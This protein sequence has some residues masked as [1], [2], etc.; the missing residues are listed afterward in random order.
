MSRPDWIGQTLGDRYQIQEIVGQGGMSAVYK[1]MDPNLQRVVAVKL[2]HSHLADDPKFVERFEEEARAVAQLRHPNIVQVYDFAEDKGVYYMVQEFVP[3]ET[4]QARM[5]R[6]DKS[7][8]NLSLDSVTKFT[9]DILSAMGYAHQR[10][11]IHRDIKPANIMLDVQGRAI[12]MDFGI[13]KIVGGQRHTATGAVVGTALY[14][15]P[16]LIR[17]EQPDERSDIYSLGVT[18]FEMVSGHPPFEAESAMTL[19]MMHLN[20]PLPNLK[21]LRPDIP[22]D[23]EAV[24]EKALAKDRNDRYKS[25]AEMAAALKKVRDRLMGNVPYDATMP[26]DSQNM[27]GPAAAALSAAALSADE[28][29][30]TIIEP[31]VK[32]SAAATGGAALD[33]SANIEMPAAE[34]PVAPPATPPPGSGTASTGG[35]SGSVPPSFPTTAPAAGGGQKLPPAVLYGG[36]GLI[37]LLAVLA[38]GW[39]I[40]SR[41]GGNE[42]PTNPAA[43]GA[44]TQ[45]TATAAATEVPATN[46]PEPTPTDTLEPS[47]TPTITLTPTL[48]ALPVRTPPGG[49]EFVRINGITIN[50]QGSYSVDYE[51]FEYTEQLPGEH[52][53]FFFNTVPEEQAGVPGNGPWILYGGPRPFTEYAPSQRPANAA[54]MCSL[55]ANPDHSIHPGSGTCWPLPDV[56][57]LTALEDTTCLS[58]PGNTYTV[59]A[60]VPKWS[61]LLLKGRLEQ[62]NWWYVQNPDNLNE[63]CW[64][65]EGGTF[66]SGPTA[67]VPV[68]VPVTPTLTLTPT[69]Y[70]N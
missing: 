29:L 40:G 2:V 10:G 69:P 57:V 19:M 26:G 24:I 51:T 61:M 38:I 27:A 35:G 41:G 4:L 33:A 59:D 28:P 12:L 30:K 3:G 65:T 34:A 64:V 45:E 9:L 58:E 1:A 36:L 20:D 68:A 39:F 7:G 49:V 32:A 22:G 46:T 23:M 15:P 62:G 18:L 14:M 11:M 8:R 52:V 63:Y 17:G 67:E 70:G 53:H 16:E 6:L 42:S 66:L 5:R 47:A 31:P 37:G 48:D 43:I 60:N 13:V 21:S 50:D 25:A 44:L 54:A 55:V 56:P